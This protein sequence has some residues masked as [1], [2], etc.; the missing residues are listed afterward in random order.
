MIATLGYVSVCGIGN[1][2]LAS[3]YVTFV[4]GPRNPTLGIPFFQF[5]ENP[6][7]KLT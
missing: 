1:C 6:A 2:N 5:A 3:F 7:T 4:T